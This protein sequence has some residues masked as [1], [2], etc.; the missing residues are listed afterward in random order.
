[1]TPERRE[2]LMLEFGRRMAPAPDPNEPYLKYKPYAHSTR[3]EPTYDV[4][5]GPLQRDPRDMDLRM[6]KQNP[7]DMP[8]ANMSLSSRPP[9]TNPFEGA[10]HPMMLQDK[11]D[12]YEGLSALLALRR[13]R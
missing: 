13:M 9:I 5:S 3:Q 6:I 10:I 1:M 4:S 2:Q 8:E 7:F 12:P 11:L